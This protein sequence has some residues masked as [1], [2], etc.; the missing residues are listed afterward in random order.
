MTISNWLINPSW[1]L[2]TD[3]DKWALISLKA[4][5]AQEK[6]HP[7]FFRLTG[8]NCF[9]KS[10]ILINTWWTNVVHE[11]AHE[12]HIESFMNS[13]EFLWTW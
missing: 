4:I 7:I 2:K 12:A 11:L 6:G 1:Q 5:V 9:D 10:W 3:S 8:M 13:H